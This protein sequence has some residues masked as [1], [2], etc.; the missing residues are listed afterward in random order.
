MHLSVKLQCDEDNRQQINTATHTKI[1]DMKVDLK[2]KPTLGDDT[3]YL[4][5][6]IKEVSFLKST[7]TCKIPT[8]SN[9]SNT[10]NVLCAVF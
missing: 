8:L 4:E 1:K 10:T 3:R 6:A 2:K 5:S 9:L 7:R